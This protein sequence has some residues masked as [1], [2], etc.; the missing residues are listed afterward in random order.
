[1]REGLLYEKVYQDL[2]HRIERGDYAKGDQLPTEKELSEF[3]GVSRITMKKA[4]S[5]LTEKGIVVRKPGLGTFVNGLAG[6]PETGRTEPA[7]QNS[8]L[9]EE[10]KAGNPAAGSVRAGKKRIACIAED[11][12]DAF[13]IAALRAITDY[14]HQEGY[15]LILN[16]SLGSQEL[17]AQEIEFVKNAGA[18]GLIIFPVMGN[19]YNKELLRAVVEDYP[20]VTINREL[21][22][23]PASCVGIDHGRAA[24]DLI[25][26]FYEKGHRKIGILGE[27]PE[28][29]TGLA[30]RY[31]GFRAAAKRYGALDGLIFF[32]E[33]REKK[34]EENQNRVPLTKKTAD[35]ILYEKEIA[36]Y[37][38]FWEDNPEITGFIGCNFGRGQMMRH[39]TGMLEMK[40]PGDLSLACFDDVGYECGD[41]SLT[42]VCQPEDEI[43]RRAI[44]L[45]KKR[46]Q[47]NRS[48]PENVV[49]DYRI[50]DCGTVGKIE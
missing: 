21:S 11:V 44:Q 8:R 37:K 36:L 40:I 49:V 9:S 42:H 18:E 39:L 29:G 1:M 6:E 13:G 46:M 38:E 3:Y 7:R 47:N 23:I 19:S 48:D 22:G 15:D 27:A 14:A 20:I 31:K 28:E 24:Y 16:L 43:A 41:I 4:M 5:I 33:W 32:H 35:K 50:Y 26:L 25:R 10:G 34:G 30:E 45:L 12:S 17:E 2:F